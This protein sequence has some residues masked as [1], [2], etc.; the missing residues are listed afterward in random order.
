[1]AKVIVDGKELS[2]EDG[3]KIEE[4]AKKY[5]NQ[6]ENDIVLSVYK[7]RLTELHKPLSGVGELSFIT[8]EDKNG[9]RTYRRSVLFLLQRALMD[10]YPSGG[11]TRLE[12]HHS[13]GQ[14]Y[15][16]TVRGEQHILQEQLDDI[17]AIMLDLVAQNIPLRKYSIKTAQA[18]ELFNNFSMGEKEQLL[19][20]RTSS[21][22]NVYDLDGCIDYF[23]GYMVPS[24]G[25]LKYFDLIPFEKGFMLML[26][27]KEPKK[28]ADFVLP[29]RLFYVQ[30]EA[31]SFGSLMKVPTV[32]ALNEAIASGR[33][34]DII[35][36]QEAFMERNIGN[37]ADKIARDKNIKFVLMAGPSSSGKTTFSHK[38]SA[39]LRALGCNPHAIS[40]DDFY[41]DRD[42]MPVDELGQKD[43]ES[44]DALDIAFFNDCMNRLLKGE[45]VQLPTFNFKTG[46][47]EFDDNCM[48][49]KDNDILVIEG[50]HGIND[51]MSAAL[52]AESKFK[53][54]LSA[55]TQLSIDEHNP[56]STSD[57]RL[58]RRIV[59]DVRTRGTSAADT[60]LMW[61]SVRRGEEK[62]IFPHQE[63]A[64][65]MFNTALIYEMAVLKL[66][67]LPHLYAISP[68]HPAYYEAKRLIKLLDYF[69][70]LAP[71]DIPNNS[72]IR[73]FIGGSCLDV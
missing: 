16:C 68:S 63:S 53:I 27:D 61:D 66:Y 48:Q 9:R 47:R 41:L 24:T 5:Q 1:M 13:L 36:S 20:Y 42:Q 14:G 34:K 3:T 57:G 22:I 7:G 70:P 23:Y 28:V 64:D 55:L 30:Q 59:R 58:I 50:I 45:Q 62:Y 56:L 4:V 11:Q 18:K 17:K 73:E 44:I 69:L 8:T 31:E 40:L 33:I 52:P 15:Y 2:Y 67:A 26:P 60:I 54:Y 65:Y 25:Y 19:F 12:I 37:L 38:L 51:R 49:L 35:L 29:Q 39:Q 10:F 32:G 21:N 43:F 6:Y 72:L 46:K 71:D